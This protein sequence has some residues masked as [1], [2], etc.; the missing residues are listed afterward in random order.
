MSSIFISIANYKDLETLNTVE[1]LISKSSGKNELKICVFSQID[2]ED[3]Y[4][5]SLDTIPQV[6]HVKIDYKLAEGVCWARAEIQKYYA[7]EDYFLQI[8]SHILFTE[9]WDTLLIEDHKKALQYGR[10]AILTAYPTCYEF[11]DDKRIIPI[12][13]PTKFILHMTNNIP[14]GL[15]KHVEEVDFPEHEYFI[16]A[17]FHFSSGDLIKKVPYDPELFFFGEEITLAIRAY[18]AGYFIFS[19]TKYIC[20]HLY[21]YKREKPLNNQRP[22]FWD[23][24]ED[25][26]RKL[27]WWMRD[28]TSRIKVY[29]ICMGNWYGKYGIQ[30]E[31]LYKEF[32]IRIKEQH[33]IDIKQ[34]TM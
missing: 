15:G 23:K 33:G 8:D 4:W 16:A 1:E 6:Q 21:N 9:N 11:E 12:K 19:P 32:A 2:L 18:T 34:A 25:T 13:S 7:N 24:D 10:K 22:I 5:D 27:R 17:G 29:H 30:D 14:S 20:A 3:N 28:T 26:K 31:I